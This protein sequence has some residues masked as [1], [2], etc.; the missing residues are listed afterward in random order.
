MRKP[1]AS[2]PTK[3][4]VSTS[5]SEEL[6]TAKKAL[7]MESL[8]DIEKKHR[9]NQISDD[10]YNKLRDR[11]KQEAVETMKKLEDIK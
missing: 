11:Y 5:D 9:A 4:K 8:K 3:T 1:K 2:K 6:L 10:T 7:L